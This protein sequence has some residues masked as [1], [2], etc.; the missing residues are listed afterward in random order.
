MEAIKKWNNFLS[1]RR[2]TLITDQKSVSFI[3]D[4]NGIGRTKNAKIAR[5]RL[6]LLGYNFDVR[7]RP[8]SKNVAADALSR[9]FVWVANSSEIWRVF[10]AHEALCHPGVERLWEYIKSRKWLVTLE[11]VRKIVSECSI[12]REVKHKICDSEC[13]LLY[14]SDAADK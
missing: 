6:E 7:Y 5:W 14:T 11:E 8:G 9:D 12:C 10:E 1:G 4:P 2:F 13:C 3:L